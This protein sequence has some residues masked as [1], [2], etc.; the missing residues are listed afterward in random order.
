MFVQTPFAVDLDQSP[1]VTA[2]QDLDPNLL[3]DFSRKKPREARIVQSSILLHDD[4]AA[5]PTWTKWIREVT[6][7]CNTSAVVGK[8]K[9]SSF[10]EIRRDEASIASVK[11]VARPS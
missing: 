4:L 6:P 7:S 11:R 5:F 1:S 3:A 8:F 2:D 9:K 10:V